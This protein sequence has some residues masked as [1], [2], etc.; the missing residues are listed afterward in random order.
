MPTTRSILKR[1][2]ACLVS[3][4]AG[5]AYGHGQEYLREY[6]KQ[7]YTITDSNNISWVPDPSSILFTM[8]CLDA[9]VFLLCGTGMIFAYDRGSTNARNQ[10]Q[11][12]QAEGVELRGVR[13]N[14][15]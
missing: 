7:E 14:R 15:P 5:Y 6:L 10:Q 9:L 3:V 12:N 1:L 4:A 8:A 2:G 11:Q 13:M